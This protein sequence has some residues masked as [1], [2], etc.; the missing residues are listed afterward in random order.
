VSACGTI[1][2]ESGAGGSAL[3][4]SWGSQSWLG[5]LLGTAFS[6]MLFT[7]RLECRGLSLPAR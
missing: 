5:S 3:H 4:K 7:E 2:A 1:R 6:P